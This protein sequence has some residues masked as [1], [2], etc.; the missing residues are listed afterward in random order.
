MSHFNR[1]LGFSSLSVSTRGLS[2]LS[3]DMNECKMN[4]IICETGGPRRLS[5]LEDGGIKIRELH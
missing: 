1:G 2:T 5:C 3:C 4:R